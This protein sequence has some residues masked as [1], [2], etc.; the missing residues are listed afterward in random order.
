MDLPRQL[1]DYLVR[2]AL[3]GRAAAWVRVT[4]AGAALESGGELGQFGLAEL[5]AGE[6]FA[7]RAEWSEGL[8]PLEGG[9][10]VL[11]HVVIAGQHA[12]VHLIP[13]G[14]NTLVLLFRA[15]R[16]ALERGSLQQMG[17]D[18]SLLRERDPARLD[19]LGIFGLVLYEQTEDA[20]LEACGAVPGWTR[21]LAW[22][23]AGGRG[24]ESGEGL[25]FLENFLVDAQAFWDAQEPGLV[26]S[27]T[28]TEAVTAGEDRSFE[29][30]ALRTRDGRNLLALERLGE[31]YEEDRKSVV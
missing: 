28:W 9:P 18:L 10:L 31:A 22:E 3:H 16:A 19:V 11:P 27:G 14:A 8:I 4:A 2:D 20:C 26:R 21:A 6:S 12:D 13:E 1:Q 24:L 23:P 15:T 30:F 5:Q 17:N 29:A 25:S 7:L